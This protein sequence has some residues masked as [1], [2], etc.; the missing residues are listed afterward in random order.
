MQSIETP[1]EQLPEAIVMNNFF[2]SE[3]FDETMD[4]SATTR[5]FQISQVVKQDDTKSGILF[6]LKEQERT[7]APTQSDQSQTFQPSRDTEYN[8]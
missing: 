8:S 5:K 7:Q 3:G 1:D 2:E 6:F 4:I